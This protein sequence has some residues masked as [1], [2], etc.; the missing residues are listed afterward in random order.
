[1]RIF[2]L[3]GSVMLA[4]LAL[5]GALQ[6]PHN[7][8]IPA[9]S[10]PAASP[11]TE[12]QPPPADAAP[13]DAAP[14]YAKIRALTYNI[15]M[16]PAPVNWRDRNACRAQRIADYFSDDA[17]AHD[18]I[19]LTESFEPASTQILA[20]STAQTYP[21]QI[22]SQPPARGLS[23]NGGV[24]I[25]SPHAIEDWEAVAF[26]RCHGKW[27]D[28][29]ATKGFVWARIRVSKSLKFNVLATHLN[30]GGGAGARATRRAQLAQIRAFLTTHPS[31]ARWPTLLMG[32]L[33]INGLRWEEPTPGEDRLSE[34]ADAMLFLAGACPHCDALPVDTYR[35]A[36]APWRYDEPQTRAVNIY[37]CVDESLQPCKSPNAAEHWKRRLRLDYILDFGA[38]RDAPALETRTLASATLEMADDSCATQYLSDH[39]ALE[40]TLEMGQFP[41]A[42][43]QLDR[44][45]TAQTPSEASKDEKASN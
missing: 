17:H 36:Q 4:G 6:T 28:C 27:N 12:A 41:L 8:H 37:N 29:L 26:E 32:D 2:A 43:A 23:I 7:P 31:I 24:S 21:H 20:R 18:I 11:T 3:S 25:L 5:L 45:D 44:Q 40:T 16:R 42:N 13:A 22:L 34:Y 1:M 33:N 39:R 30:S 19:V 35:A 15:F 10:P 14:A 38:P 9:P